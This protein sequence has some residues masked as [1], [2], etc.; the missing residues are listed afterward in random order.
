MANNEEKGKRLEK[1]NEQIE[2]KQNTSNSHS[3]FQKDDLREPE[4]LYPTKLLLYTVFR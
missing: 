2:Q 4:M 1:C 3:L